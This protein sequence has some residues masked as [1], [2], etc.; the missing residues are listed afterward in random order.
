MAKLTPQQEIDRDKARAAA[1]QKALDAE[2]ALPAAE[3]AFKAIAA[4][5]KEGKVVQT[6][7]IRAH[8][9]TYGNRLA[10]LNDARKEV[11]RLKKPD[12]LA[13]TPINLVSHEKE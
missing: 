5:A 7:D 2:N 11:A 13:A 6:D 8:A 3:R 12:A 1:K 4:E 9:V 10:E